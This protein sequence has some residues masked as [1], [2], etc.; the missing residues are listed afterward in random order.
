MFRILSF[1]LPLIVT[2]YASECTLA[3]AQQFRHCSQVKL[4]SHKK[5]NDCDSLQMARAEVIVYYVNIDSFL[6]F[7]L[8]DKRVIKIFTFF[9][10]TPLQLWHK[11]LVY[12]HADLCQSWQFVRRQLHLRKCVQARLLCKRV[13]TTLTKKDQSIQ[14]ESSEL[15]FRIIYMAK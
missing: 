9:L 13:Y 8:I 6:R 1:R 2:F 10:N 4:T 5:I 11:C 12:C 3:R 14:F 15:N 7:Y